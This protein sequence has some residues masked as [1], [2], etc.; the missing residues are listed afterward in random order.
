[1]DVYLKNIYQLIKKDN[2]DKSISKIEMMNQLE[3]NI[4]NNMNENIIINEDE[5]NL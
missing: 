4:D 5:N 3:A 2:F 1:M